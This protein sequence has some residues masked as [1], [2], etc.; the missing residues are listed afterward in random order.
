MFMH[1]KAEFLQ[2]REASVRCFNRC[3]KCKKLIWK[4]CN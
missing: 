1:G 3:G 2:T 4:T